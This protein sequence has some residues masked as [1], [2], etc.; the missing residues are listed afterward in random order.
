M[1]ESL[2][3]ALD[4]R[5]L[6]LMSGGAAT[7]RGAPVIFSASGVGIQ[8]VEAR[9]R[10]NASNLAEL[11]NTHRTSGAYFSEDL[12]VLVGLACRIVLV[13]RHAGQAGRIHVP[14]FCQPCLAGRWR[15]ALN[16]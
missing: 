14:W 2:G 4:F 8:W 16:A 12:S 9:G 7:R 15:V 10:L 6:C 13:D 3:R 5:V 1:I 11:Q